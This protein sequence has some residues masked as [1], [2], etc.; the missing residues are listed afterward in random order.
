ADA[1]LSDLRTR[2]APEQSTG[3][4]RGD[5]RRLFKQVAEP[6]QVAGPRTM[7]AL[8]GDADSGLLAL[9][10]NGD[11]RSALERLDR[12]IDDAR[13]RGELGPDPIPRSALMAPIGLLHAE[14]LDHE[15]PAGY[16]DEVI[17]LVAIPLYRLRSRASSCS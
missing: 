15:L 10:M 8:I 16:L 4:L 11:Q 9:L 6:A 13:I 5:L 2:T 17:D 1:L 7:R 14:L 3:S 12:I